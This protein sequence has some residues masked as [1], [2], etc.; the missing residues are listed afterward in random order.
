MNFP[1]REKNGKSKHEIKK[2]YV[3]GRMLLSMLGKINC[4]VVINT[5][6]VRQTIYELLSKTVAKE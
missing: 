4:C 5:S 3:G 1:R 2:T 6:G